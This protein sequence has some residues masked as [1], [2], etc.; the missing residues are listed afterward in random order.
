LSREFPDARG[1]S[2]SLGPSL[3]ASLGTN[4]TISA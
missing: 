2:T 1:S 3:C 4:L